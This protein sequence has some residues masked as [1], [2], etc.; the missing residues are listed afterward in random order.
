MSVRTRSVLKAVALARFPYLHTMRF[1]IWA[2]FETDDPMLAK[3]KDTA[4]QNLVVF[5]SCGAE[6]VSS[7]FT[8]SNDLPRCCHWSNQ[9]SGIADHAHGIRL[10]AEWLK[11]RHMPPLRLLPTVTSQTCHPTNRWGSVLAVLYLPAN[12]VVKNNKGE[13][14]HVDPVLLHA[15]TRFATS[16]SFGNVNDCEDCL[17]SVL[18]GLESAWQCHT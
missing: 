12:T 15:A 7:C 2:G 14:P 9:T 18:L 16:W 6:H 4:I 8:H 17:E 11:D 10:L 3:D 1:G 13:L 5:S